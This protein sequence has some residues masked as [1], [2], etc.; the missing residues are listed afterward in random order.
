[1][2]RCKILNDEFL[3][4]VDE[5]IENYVKDLPEEKKNVQREQRLRSL[6]FMWNNPSSFVD[7]P[8]V[9]EYYQKL[10]IYTPEYMEMPFLSHR[11]R[12]QIEPVIKWLN[13]IKKISEIKE[14][15]SYE[16]IQ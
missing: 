9:V 13:Q 1:M 15:F 2:Y 16:I 7:H 4:K 3:A 14:I 8:E 6:Y 12:F 10:G 5:Y 11:T